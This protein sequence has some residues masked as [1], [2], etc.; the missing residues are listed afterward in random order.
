MFS[1]AV[2]AYNE[3]NGMGRRPGPRLLLLHVT[4]KVFQWHFLYHFFVSNIC[5]FQ[6]LIKNYQQNN[7]VYVEKSSVKKGNNI[8][9]QV[10]R[11][12]KPFLTFLSAFHE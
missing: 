12:I 3:K 9:A 11:T 7:S 5:T 10:G 1:I 8:T 4:E 2:N 6:L